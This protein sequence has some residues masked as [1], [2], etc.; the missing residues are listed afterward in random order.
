MLHIVA[1]N[2]DETS[3]AVDRCLIDDG[4]SR[5]ASACCGVDPPT[6]ELT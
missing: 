6:T 2:E 3:S 4:Q 1:A 5:L